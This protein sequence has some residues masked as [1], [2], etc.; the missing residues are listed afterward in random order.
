MVTSYWLSS[1][2]GYWSFI[3]WL[4][5]VSVWT[6]RRGWRPIFRLLDRRMYRNGRWSKML[7]FIMTPVMVV[8]AAMVVSIFM[9]HGCW[10]RCNSITPTVQRMAK[11]RRQAY[12]L[13]STK[14]SMIQSHVP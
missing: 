2:G 10:T 1:R 4:V 9:R 3:L 5:G 13:Y 7:L 14:H 8:A 6:A 12:L 11:I